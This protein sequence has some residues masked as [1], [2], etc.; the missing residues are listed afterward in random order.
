MIFSYFTWPFRH[1]HSS[2]PWTLNNKA[3]TATTTDDEA[4]LCD[5]S[6]RNLWLRS[7]KNCMTGKNNCETF[8]LSEN[9]LTLVMYFCAKCKD[10][11]TR[12]YREKYAQGWI[13]GGKAKWTYKGKN[14]VM[15]PGT[16]ACTVIVDSS[17]QNVFIGNMEKQTKDANIMLKYGVN[18]QASFLFV[19]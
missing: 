10:L 2:L 19:L 12:S 13:W 1:D 14:C 15:I 3:T 18:C 6:T 7:A 11:G 16:L 9:I 17:A 4:C 8:S 5:K